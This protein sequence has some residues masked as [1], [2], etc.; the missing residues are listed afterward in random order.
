MGVPAGTETEVSEGRGLPAL[1]GYAT[2][3]L[4]TALS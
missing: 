3:S 1:R 2:L 4:Q